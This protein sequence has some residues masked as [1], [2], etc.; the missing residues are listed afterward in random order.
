M[1]VSRNAQILAILATTVLCLGPAALT[2]RA[3]DTLGNWNVAEQ[4]QVV[5]DHLMTVEA[6]GG[7]DG[8][9]PLS[10]TDM[11]GILAALGAKPGF[12]QVS[13]AS[14]LTVEGFDSA[15]VDA[16]GLADVAD[17]VQW[18]TAAAGLAPPS[19]FGSEVLARA[20][21]LR[22]DH[23]PDDDS[24]E[25]FPTDAITRAEAA[26]SLYVIA[27]LSPAAV[28]SIRALYDTY[29]LPAYTPDELTPLTL[30]ASEIGMPYV[31]GGDSS[32]STGLPD[33]QV[34]GG[35]DC[36]GF[37]W[38]VYKISANPA[39]LQVD[40]R[41]AAQMAGEIPNSSRIALNA[42]APGD[43]LFFGTAAFSGPATE[44]SITHSAIA[45]S[46]QWAIQS[47][48]QG[49]NVAPLTSGWLQTSFAWGRRILSPVASAAATSQTTVH[50]SSAKPARAHRQGAPG[51]PPHIHTSTR[52]ST[53]GAGPT[54]A[55]SAPVD[56][57][58]GTVYP[59]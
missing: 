26:H 12:T 43:L 22:Y 2:A 5:A 4:R 19:Y 36:S 34:H 9:L 47:S 3:S 10:D 35:F 48:S 13:S 49:V 24:L 44:A 38:W 17:R 31:W 37:I 18:L 57:G 21:G 58:G 28:Q 59:G 33:T 45:L 32:T 7:F 6:D 14:N 54:G 30:A 56:I 41:T 1:A 15:M 52:S 39:G 46:S 20:L 42:V 51:K 40:G 23:P 50:S 29:S 25:L 11:Q 55:A 8:Q 16:L 53:S 27:S